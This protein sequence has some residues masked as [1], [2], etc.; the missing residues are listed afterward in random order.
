MAGVIR[1]GHNSAMTIALSPKIDQAPKIDRGSALP[2]MILPFALAVFVAFGAGPNT[3]LAVLALAVLVAGGYLLWRPG[4]PPIL[5][6]LF[7]YQWGGASISVFYSNAVGTDISEF[8]LWGGQTARAALLSIVGLFFLSLG[9]RCG[10]GKSDPGIGARARVLAA[11]RPVEAWFRLYLIAFGVAF[12]ATLLQSIL[13]SLAQIFIALTSLKWAFFWRLGYAT[14]VQGKSARRRYF[15]AAFC[16]EFML[17]IGGYFSDFKTVILFT[18]FAMI[19]AKT[20]LRLRAAISVGLMFALLIAF[21][22]IWT[23]IKLPYRQFV[24]GG[25]ASQ[26]VTVSYVAGIREL[27]S[28][29]AGLDRPAL[30]LS[31]NDLIHRIS[32]VY[33]FGVVLDNDPSSIPH[34]NGA[35]WADAITRPLMPRILFPGKPAIDDTARTNFYTG[36][37]LYVADATSV[38]IGYIG[39][40]YIDFGERLMMLPLFLL[41]LFYGGIYR[42]LLTNRRTAGPLGMGLACAILMIGMALESS[43]TKVFGGICVTLLVVWLVVRFIVPRHLPWVL[44]GAPTGAPPRLPA[45]P[46]AAPQ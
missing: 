43:I 26:N 42:W 28:L 37:I 5:L 19:A 17:G 30:I 38:S 9:M 20:R 14:L 16:L 1:L 45:P 35:L 33:F 25:E 10:A 29:I 8:S 32:Y 39:E 13:P 4:E 18:L 41:G 15:V 21:G 11:S 12:F 24:S 36:G 44:T 46:P 3:S 31:G 7:A 22:V 6:L 23:A 27:D 2:P 40:A 34:E